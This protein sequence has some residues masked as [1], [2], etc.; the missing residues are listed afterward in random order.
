M[1]PPKVTIFTEGLLEAGA[2]DQYK[3]GKHPRV[4][5]A[6]AFCC[7]PGLGGFFG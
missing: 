4:K 5:A 3:Q 6:G 7:P 1:G 2:Q